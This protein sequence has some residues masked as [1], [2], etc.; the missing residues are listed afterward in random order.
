MDPFS[1]V[2]GLA[3]LVSLAA[4]LGSSLAAFQH[5]YRG[6]RESYARLASELAAVVSTLSMLQIH[7]KKGLNIGAAMLLQEPIDQCAVALAKIREECL[8]NKPMSKRRRWVWAY[9]DERR[10]L[11]F[12]ALLER[13]KGMFNVALNL[14]LS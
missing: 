3:G 13:Y 5:S 11:D 8:P 14:D 12:I 6:A 1:F 7:I 2:T 10:V 9:S 4:Q